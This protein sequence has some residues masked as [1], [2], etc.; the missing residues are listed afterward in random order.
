VRSTIYANFFSFDDHNLVLYQNFLVSY[1]MIPAH[2]VI[3]TLE[4][5]ELTSIITE[6]NE[7]PDRASEI[8]AIEISLPEEDEGVAENTG[9][10]T[11][12]LCAAEVEASELTFY[13][14]ITEIVRPKTIYSYKS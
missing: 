13:A 14:R 10:E 12:K 11:T 4:S 1:E 9:N 3:K 7:F 2:L 8:K 5:P 6:L